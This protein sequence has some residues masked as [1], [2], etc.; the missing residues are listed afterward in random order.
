[1]RARKRC[2]RG[3]KRG[4]SLEKREVSLPGVKFLKEKKKKNGGDEKGTLSVRKGVFWQLRGPVSLKKPGV[5]R[6][7]SVKRK[8]KSSKGLALR[9]KKFR[10][11]E[12]GKNPSSTHSRTVKSSTSVQG[13]R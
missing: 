3:G 13:K 1:L 4:P 6:R 8:K 10:S 12:G 2:T 11:G 9:K 5:Q 7:N